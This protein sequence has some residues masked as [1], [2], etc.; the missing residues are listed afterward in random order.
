MLFRNTSELQN[1]MSERMVGL[2]CFFLFF[3]KA[4]QGQ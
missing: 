4:V 1:E 2:L 3:F